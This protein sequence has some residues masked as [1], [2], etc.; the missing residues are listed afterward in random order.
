MWFLLHHFPIPQYFLH[1]SNKLLS[2]IV[3][4]LHMKE[5]R[6]NVS[7][8]EF[9]GKDIFFLLEWLRQKL[10]KIFESSHYLRVLYD[11]CGNYYADELMAPL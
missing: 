6:I 7:F 2:T 8:L 11:Q 9:K 1:P 5:K 3:I 10:S 4:S